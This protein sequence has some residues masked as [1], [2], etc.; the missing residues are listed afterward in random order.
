MGTNLRTYM[1][2]MQWQEGKYVTVYPK[3]RAVGSMRYIPLR[4]WSERR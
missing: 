1:A 3:E 2:V 4:R